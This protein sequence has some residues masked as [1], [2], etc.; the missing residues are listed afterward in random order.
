MVGDEIGV[1]NFYNLTTAK[2]CAPVASTLALHPRASKSEWC[3]LLLWTQSVSSSRYAIMGGE[4]QFMDGVA[5]DE[6]DEACLEAITDTMDGETRRIFEKMRES[7][8][9]LVHGR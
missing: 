1:A 9:S 5:D 4:L 6:D 2:Y 7:R 3:G 8:S